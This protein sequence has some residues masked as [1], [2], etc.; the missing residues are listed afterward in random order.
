MTKEEAKKRIEEL[1]KQI[2]HHNYLYYVLNRP[3]ISDAEY[4]RLMAELISLE[5]QFPDLI[6]PDS[7]TQKIGAPPKEEFGKIDHLAPMLSLDSCLDEK[8]V[9]DFDRRVKREL[10]V[11]NVEYVVEPK[12][13]GLSVELVYEKGVFVRGSTRGDGLVGEDVTDNL[14]T[15]RPVPLKL[16]EGKVK[17]PD[18]LA[19]RG[20]VV[21]KIKDFEKLNEEMVRRGEPPFAN[22]RNA[23]SGSLRQLDSKITA[24]RKLDIFFYDILAV[25][26]VK[27]NS[28]WEVLSTLPEWGLKVSSDIRKCKNIEEVYK[29]H[30]EMEEKREALDFEIDGIVVKVN[31]FEYQSRLGIKTRS[32]RWAVAYKFKPKEEVTRIKDIIVQVGRTGI[33]TPVAILEP[34]KIGG[35]TV[36]R[37]TLHNQDEIDRKDV[38]IGD[39]VVVIRAGDVIPEIKARVHVEGEKRREKYHLPNKCP[40]CGADVVRE[41]AYYRCTGGLSCTAQL[42]ESLRHFA[43]KGA[44]NIEGLGK[45]LVDKFVDEGIIRSPVDL[46]HLEKEQIAKLEGMGDKSAQNLLDSIEKSKEIELAR[47][48]YALGIPL[49]GEHLARVLAQHYKSL[50]K[51]ASATEEELMQIKEIGPE[52]ARSIVRFF[53]QEGNRKVIEGLLKAGIRFKEIKVEKPSKIAGLK[54]VFTGKLESFSREEAK[55]MVEELGGIASSSVS[56]E[57]DYLVVGEDPGSKLEKAKKLGIKIITE[58]EFKELIGK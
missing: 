34:V 14:K 1:R 38:R 16:R 35:V 48:I 8:E 4:D 2:N 41:G 26:G 12:F 43:S 47:F 46:Y 32:P 21:M 36:T 29:Y 25:E 51:L 10:G 40:V 28:Q 58:K 19:V 5:S 56:R 22:P 18:L 39:K 7:P 42:K 54:F 27:L 6:T 44:M 11:D 20:E 49:V 45:K 53:R 50:E 33:L 9:E 13:D 52:S 24:E 30:H 23:A 57:T 15:V 3:E 37:A 31:Q 55:R 17:I